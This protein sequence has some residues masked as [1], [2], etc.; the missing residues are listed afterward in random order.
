MDT[1]YIQNGDKVFTL[2][3]YCLQYKLAS[4][5]AQVVFVF[6]YP[7]SVCQYSSYNN[8]FFVSKKRKANN[9]LLN[10]FIICTIGPIILIRYC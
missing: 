5:N 10:F 9:L 6:L 3:V 4:G 1:V 2:S 7:V 8:N